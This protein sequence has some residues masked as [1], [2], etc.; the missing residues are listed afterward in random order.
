M[1]PRDGPGCFHL[2][3]PWLPEADPCQHVDLSDGL[4]LKLDGDFDIDHI[5]HDI[6]DDIDHIDH[7][8]RDVDERGLGG[9]RR[10]GSGLPRRRE[11]YAV[12]G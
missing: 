5:D 12:G 4:D 2:H 8:I 7:N 3:L 6:G 1:A 11:V 10:L 9:V